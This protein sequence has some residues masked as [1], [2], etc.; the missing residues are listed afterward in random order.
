MATGAPPAAEVLALAARHLLGRGRLN[1]ARKV[2]GAALAEDPR[3]A[4]AHTVMHVVCDELGDWVAGLGH[5][6][7][8]AEL[9]P[10]SAQLRYNLALSA[11]RP[12]RLP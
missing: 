8:A 11:L 9:L 3:C 2:A 4:N 7:R 6:R 5:A 1:L 12:R 10:A